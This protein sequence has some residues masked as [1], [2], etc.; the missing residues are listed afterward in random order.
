MGSRLPLAVRVGRDD[1]VPDLRWQDEAAAEIAGADG[2][3]G[4]N[5]KHDAGAGGG[6]DAFADDERPVVVVRVQSD[7]ASPDG[8]EADLRR[9][10]IGLPGAVRAQ[11]GAVH[12][13]GLAAASTT[14]ATI[15]GSFGPPPG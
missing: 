10:D 2:R 5:L 6:L 13:D 12:R 1:D 4:G 14:R 15:A 8:T 3:P 9:L 11:V 7:C